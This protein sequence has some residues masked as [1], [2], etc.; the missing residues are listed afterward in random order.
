LAPPLPIDGVVAAKQ[1][2]EPSGIAVE[3][4]V[5]AGV[6]HEQVEQLALMKEQLLG[7]QVLRPAQVLEVPANDLFQ[8]LPRTSQ[9]A[10]RSRGDVIHCRRPIGRRRDMTH[11]IEPGV[12]LGTVSRSN[13]QECALHSRGGDPARDLSDLLMLSEQKH[14]DRTRRA[15]ESASLQPDRRRLARAVRGLQVMRPVIFRPVAGTQN[16]GPSPE[17]TSTA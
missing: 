5:R 17:A 1:D 8:R 6:A 7:R 10:T 13:E 9:G 14:C 12:V 11:I 16:P 4:H 15:A 3:R 2:I